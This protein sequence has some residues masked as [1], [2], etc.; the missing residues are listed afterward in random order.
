MR[1]RIGT[2][3]IRQ[4]DVDNALSKQNNWSDTVV[5][6]EKNRYDMS[7]RYLVCLVAVLGQNG[8]DNLFSGLLPQ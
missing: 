8:S 6:R 3:P 2:V 7:I 4:V 5:S 1:R